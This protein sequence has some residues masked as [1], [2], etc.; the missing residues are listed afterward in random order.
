MGRDEVISIVLKIDV[1]GQKPKI[2]NP[3]IFTALLN[4][5]YYDMI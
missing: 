5:S 3:N 1:T 4:N 2:I